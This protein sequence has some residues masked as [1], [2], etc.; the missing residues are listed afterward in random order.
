MTK[1]ELLKQLVPFDV[2]EKGKKERITVEGFTENEHKY[3]HAGRKGTY[4]GK[5]R[6]RSKRGCENINAQPVLFR[7]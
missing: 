1:K 2:I 6:L 5:N 3:G 7:F 4:N